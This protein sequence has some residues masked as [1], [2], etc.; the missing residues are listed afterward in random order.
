MASQVSIL[1]MAVTPV[2]APSSSAFSSV[3]SFAVEY[4]V[5]CLPLSL[6]CTTD[7]LKTVIAVVAVF[8]EGMTLYHP[9]ES[10]NLELSVLGG[11][12]AA[13]GV[14]AFQA[15]STGAYMYADGHI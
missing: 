13:I 4:R 15:S 9:V 8:V 5:R 11:V 2:A 6:D 14:F 3:H 7:V 10:A 1:M 12:I